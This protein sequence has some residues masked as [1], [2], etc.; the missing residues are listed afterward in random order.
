MVSS[1]AV[2]VVLGF[3]IGLS[4]FLSYSNYRT[5]FETIILERISAVADELKS[6]LRR[7]IRI[8]RLSPGLGRSDAIVDHAA[9][10]HPDITSITF[11]AKQ[12]LAEKP[13]SGAINERTS[14]KSSRFTFNAHGSDAKVVFPDAGKPMFL[15]WL[16][17]QDELV[18]LGDYL[19]IEVSTLRYDEKMQGMLS[20]FLWLALSLYIVSS[21]LSCVGCYL[22][23]RPLRACFAK[24]T[25]DVRLLL[26]DVDPTPARPPA[27]TVEEEQFL[28][29]HAN[30]KIIMN[31]LKDAERLN[32]IDH[33]RDNAV[34]DSET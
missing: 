23:Y 26:S 21:L 16:P 24:M 6:D 2:S 22:F 15:Y 30:T 27:S 19:R 7:D 1:L 12:V 3:A 29:F 20:R 14:T 17:L 28:E 8:N 13:E 31:V 25:K 9:S 4:T 5:A 10:N 33:A 34:G 32:T 11:V 18:N